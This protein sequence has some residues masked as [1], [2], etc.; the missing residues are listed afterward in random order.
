MSDRPQD[1]PEDRRRR[2]PLGDEEGT[3]DTRPVP[4]GG[5]DAETGQLSSEGDEREG[6]TRENVAGSSGG[7]ARREAPDQDD[8]HT[9]VNVELERAIKRAH[10]L[11]AF[12]EGVPYK[13]YERG[14]ERQGH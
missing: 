14:K 4:R 3:E 10:E 5:E 12:L 9:R 1:R 8:P 13:R 7:T 6:A 11:D 2:G